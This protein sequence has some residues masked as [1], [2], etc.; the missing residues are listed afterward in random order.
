VSVLLLVPVFKS[1]L[2]CPRYVKKSV[3]RESRRAALRISLELFPIRF[4][5]ATSLCCIYKT[6]FNHITAHIASHHAPYI[7]RYVFIEIRTEKWGKGRRKGKGREGWRWK[8]CSERQVSLLVSCKA[9]Q[10]RCDRKRGRN[11]VVRRQG[12]SE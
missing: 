8:A 1:E 3:V 4:L 7:K 12:M 9:S 2:C 5:H 10:R 11:P 6:A